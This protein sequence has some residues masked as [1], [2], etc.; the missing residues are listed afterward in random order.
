VS[1]SAGLVELL[2][3][4]M[5]DSVEFFQYQDKPSS[6]FIR[7]SRGDTEIPL[8]KMSGSNSLGFGCRKLALKILEDCG[9]PPQSIRLDI[10]K[11]PKIIDGQS[12]YRIITEIY[13]KK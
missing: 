6:W 11:H 1:L 9:L 12:Y 8:R 4:E 7:K 5:G 13:K 10:D 2:H 3:V